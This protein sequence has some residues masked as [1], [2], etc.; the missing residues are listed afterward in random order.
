M[1]VATAGHIDHGKTSLVHAIT[2]V[3]TD[4]LPEERERGIS[5]DLGFAYWRPASDLT[6]GFVDVP[7]HERFVRNMLAG[8]AAVDFALVVVAADDGVMP[9]TIEHVQILD[10]MGINRGAIAIT[11]VDRVSPEQR[12]EARAQISQLLAGTHFHDAPIVEVSS[13]TGEGVEALKQ[14]LLRAAQSETAQPPAARNF[15]LAI[16]RAFSVPGAGT[17]VTG[18]V[19]DGGLETGRKLIIAPG[20]L[21]TRVRGLQSAGSKVD[22]VKAGMRCAANLTDVEVGQISRGDWL[23]TP[24]MFAPTTRLEARI[25]LMAT[26]QTPLKHLSKVHLHV[27]AADLSA[28][29]LIPRQGSIAPD[30]SDIAL[31]ALDA[32]TIAVNGDRFILRDASGRELI[33]GGSV[34]DP[35]ARPDRRRAGHHAATTAALE[36]DD[37]HAAFAELL[38]LPEVEIDATWFERCYNLTRRAADDIY[39][40]FPIIRIGADQT[41]VVSNARLELVADAIA[42]LLGATHRTQPQLPGLS[43]KELKSRLGQSVSVDLLRTALKRLEEARRIEIGPTVHLKGHAPQFSATESAL[44]RR[45][46]DWEEETSLLAFSTRDLS[47]ELGANE[48]TIRSMLSARQASGEVWAINAT[49]YM[50]RRP[51]AELAATAA[52]LARSD[53]GFTAAQFRDA[54]GLGRNQLIRILEFFDRIGVTTRNGDSRK[55]KQNYEHIVGSAQPYRRRTKAAP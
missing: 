54:T 43:V 48:A 37:P 2:S 50:L 8:V 3:D 7:G 30:Q 18:T 51:V 52:E 29:V 44:W 12:K 36:H 31:I 49:N 4:R 19:F 11:K 17:V 35:L 27:G 42:E 10:L 1:L 14:T 47:K 25:K 40:D 9:Q 26:R 24:E 38:A 23:V 41:H 21:E 55:M 34:I 33:G 46:L 32:P 6:I 16:D 13:T 39:S 28:R 53:A 15:R 5:I 45:A 20:G 22:A